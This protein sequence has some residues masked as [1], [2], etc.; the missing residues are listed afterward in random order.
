MFQVPPLGGADCQSLLVALLAGRYGRKL[1]KD[2]LHALSDGVLA[3]DTSP[4][5]VHLLGSFVRHWT[6]A[7]VI[8][9]WLVDSV[10]TTLDAGLECLLTGLERCYGAG[11][12]ARTLG[13]MTLAELGLTDAELDDALSL[14]DAVFDALASTAKPTLR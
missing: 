11:L 6:S 1:S 14:D 4:M 9:P 12:V 10:P 7:D 2:Q 13:L 8:E 3:S 5:L